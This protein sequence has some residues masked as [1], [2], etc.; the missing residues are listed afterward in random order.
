MKKCV[1][2]LLLLVSSDSTLSLNELSLLCGSFLIVTVCCVCL[3]FFFFLL[4]IFFV[5][6]MR[7]RLFIGTT[8][9]FTLVSVFFAFC[10]RF[11]AVCRAARLR[12]RLAS[13]FAGSWLPV[14]TASNMSRASWDRGFDAR[15]EEAAFLL[16]LLL[17]CEL[18]L[19]LSADNELLSL[20]AFCLLFEG[21]RALFSLD[22]ISLP[23]T[24]GSCGQKRR[25]VRRLD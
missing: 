1:K 16:L 7:L 24:L 21:A 8:L 20:F 5:S 4:N 19:G 18:L 17:R 11:R 14:A 13:S 12:G 22:A 9:C 2:P 25:G 15:D 3:F 23:P 10:F 6:A